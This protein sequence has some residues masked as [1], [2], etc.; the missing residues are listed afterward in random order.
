ML[1]RRFPV[2]RGLDK[3]NLGNANVDENRFHTGTTLTFRRLNVDVVGVTW[4]LFLSKTQIPSTEAHEL[5]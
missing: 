1:F 3:G 4:I 5:K 2:D